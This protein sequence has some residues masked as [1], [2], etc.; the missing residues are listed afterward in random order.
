MNTTS[1]DPES[2]SEPRQRVFQ[3]VPHIRRFQSSIIRPTRSAWLNIAV[4]LAGIT[5]LVVLVY[6]F[7]FSGSPIVRSNT[8]DFSQST[9]LIQELSTVKSHIHFAVVVSE[10]S[11]SIIVRRLA[12]QA[13]QI[14]ARGLGAALF[15]DPTM[16]VQLHGVATYGVRVD[17]LN[18]RVRQTDS[19]VYV[20]LPPAEVL[21][22]KLIAADT[23][24]IARM[25][26]LFRSSQ[27]S[28]LLAATRNGETFVRQYAVEDS[29]LLR[30]A[31]QRARDLMR[32]LIDRTG[33]RAEFES[34][35]ETG[36]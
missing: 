17:D 11:G 32:L 6:A 8:I 25:E 35:G 27:H 14:D 26:G 15:Q 2:R 23:R 34:P 5:I 12:D 36:Q 13:K 29:T 18:R 19:V 30:V 4:L 10:E 21:D 22:V 16:I 33:K 28:L 20:D 24:P 7:V 1:A 9:E 31:E 3:K